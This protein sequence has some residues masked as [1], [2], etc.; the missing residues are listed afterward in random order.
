MRWAARLL[1]LTAAPQAPAQVHLIVVSGLSGEPRYAE[2]FHGW[3]T[4]LCD[5]AAQRWGVPESNIVYLA[6]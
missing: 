6:E 1:W 4:Q 3:A 5:A 2:Q